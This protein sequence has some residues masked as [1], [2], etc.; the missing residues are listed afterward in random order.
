MIYDY[1]DTVEHESET[2]LPAEAVSLNG[3]F[4]ENIIGGRKDKRITLPS[5]RTDS[6][7]STALQKRQRF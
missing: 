2:Y 7:L 3:T 1:V 5:E 4:L 6:R